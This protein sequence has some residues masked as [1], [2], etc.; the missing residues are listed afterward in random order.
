MILKKHLNSK[1]NGNLGAS[2]ES[3]GSQSKAVEHEPQPQCQ[4]PFGS[5]Y[6]TCIS[7][8]CPRHTSEM[9]RANKS[10]RKILQLFLPLCPPCSMWIVGCSC[11]FGE[12]SQTTFNTA[13]S[14]DYR[15][16]CGG[17][18]G[19]STWMGKGLSLPE[20]S[21]AFPT[22]TTTKNVPQ[23][24]CSVVSQC[25]SA[26]KGSREVSKIYVPSTAQWREKA[27]PTLTI[28]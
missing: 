16:G 4:E 5:C 3:N 1:N 6:L 2:P 23:L 8:P 28:Q 12:R 17:G 7:W 10:T 24:S 19:A 26:A 25:S 18:G 21:L 20:L 22:P 14:E 15:H 9:G 11:C 13:P 27:M